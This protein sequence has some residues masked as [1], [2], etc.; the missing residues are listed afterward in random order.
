MHKHEF[1]KQVKAY[2][3]KWWVSRHFPI[4]VLVSRTAL[5]KAGMRGPSAHVSTS[6]PSKTTVSQALFSNTEDSTDTQ[7]LKTTAVA[8]SH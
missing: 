5:I 6:L 4:A 7:C 2:V 8:H 3:L 1:K